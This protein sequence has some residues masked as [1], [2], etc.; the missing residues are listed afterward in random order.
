MCSSSFIV[1][2]QPEVSKPVAKFLVPDRGIYSPMAL[3]CRTGPPAYDNPMPKSTV[4]FRL[5]LRIWLVG[6]RFESNSEIVEQ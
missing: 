6:Y 4:F 1:T 2:I 5:E 3:G